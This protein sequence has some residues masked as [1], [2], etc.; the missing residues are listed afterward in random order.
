MKT[1]EGDDNPTGSTTLRVPVSTFESLVGSV[2]TLGTVKSAT[3]HGQDVTARYVDLQA[4]LTAARATLDQLYTIL[5][6]AS[7]VGDV[8]AVQDRIEATQTNIDELQGELN[9]VNDQ[10]SYAALSVDVAQQGAPAAGATTPQSGLAKAWHDAVH[11]FTH[12]IEAIIAH[13]GTVLLVLLIGVCL[14]FGIRAGW[15]WLLRHLV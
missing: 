9:V 3:T 12:G 1:A 8:L 6:N 15:P 14:F 7:A 2:R 5:H 13:S 11:G 4:R 10:T